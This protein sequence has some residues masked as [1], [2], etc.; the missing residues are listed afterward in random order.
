MAKYRT[1][2]L[3]GAAL[4]PGEICDCKRERERETV[5]EERRADIR[6]GMEEEVSIRLE[7]RVGSET[8][9]REIKASSGPAALNGLAML[10]KECAKMMGLSTLEVLALLATALTVPAIRVGDA[11]AEK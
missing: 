5:Y 10:L 4:D 7:K 11:G 1:C 6:P 2:E 9:R 3:C 8:F